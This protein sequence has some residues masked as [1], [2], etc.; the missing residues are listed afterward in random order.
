MLS[1]L[2]Q[3][4]KTGS[5]TRSVNFLSAAHALSTGCFGNNLGYNPY[6][7]GKLYS[8]LFTMKTL[9]YPLV[10]AFIAISALSAQTRVVA[11]RGFWDCE[12]SA[13][14]SIASL[15]NAHEAQVYGS[16]L[17]VIITADGVP[18]VHH[19]DSIQ[20]LRIEEADYA[21]IKDLQLSNGEVLPTLESYLQRFLTLPDMKLVVEIKPHLRIVNEDRAVNAVVFL[22]Q[23]Y[24]LEDKVDY[25]SF[26]MNICKELVARVPYASVAY[27]N[28]EVSP[29]DLKV[30]GMNMDYHYKVFEKH[31]GWIA[32]AKALG[33]TVNVWTVN[34]E[35]VMKS[36][37]EQ[38]VDFITTD[39]PVELNRLLHP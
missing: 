22:I 11:H 23:K 38:G 20:G 39:K 18:V 7:C 17:D 8:N 12:G 10:L 36:L 33:V 5:G 13:Q 34:D 9:F 32:E 31:P 2:A 29:A 14:N 21:Q 26:S 4:Q 25:I 6:I 27:L 28:G 35:A 15:V 24:Q 30:L 16:E 3:F 19:D 37:I 1:L